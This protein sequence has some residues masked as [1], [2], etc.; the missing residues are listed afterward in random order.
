MNK[1]LNIFL[2]LVLALCTLT[3]ASES[4]LSSTAKINLHQGSNLTNLLPAGSHHGCAAADDQEHIDLDALLKLAEEN[5]K[6]L[7]QDQPVLDKKT[8][9]LQANNAHY[10]SLQRQVLPEGKVKFADCLETTY[11]YEDEPEN[12]LNPLLLQAINENRADDVEKLLDDGADID[13]KTKYSVSALALSAKSANLEIFKLLLTKNPTIQGENSYSETILHQAVKG[14]NPKIIS[15][16]LGTKQLPKKYL[17]HKSAFDETPLKLAIR[18]RNPAI[19]AQ[20]L[21]VGAQLQDSDLVDEEIM[22]AIQEQIIRAR[23]STEQKT[24]NK[25]FLDVVKSSDTC[26]VINYICNGANVNARDDL[27]E[28]ALM[29]ACASAN[30]DAVEQLVKLGADLD[31]QNYF[32]AATA[33]HQAIQAACLPVIKKLV[34]AGTSLTIKDQNN[35]TPVMLA[36][37]INKNSPSHINLEI[38]NY[39]SQVEARRKLSRKLFSTSIGLSIGVGAAMA[40]YSIWQKL[41]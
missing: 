27:G 37:Q 36:K 5:K 40:A 35:S 21:K 19:F 18:N 14:N 15:A 16:L 4:L 13:C 29:L 39:L 10:Q 26:S 8:K 41:R 30:E 25:Q 31:A 24:L 23:S 12:E 28:T 17:A 6:L 1:L 3:F 9:I 20:L 22:P 7:S 2:P 33:T 11:E 32:G 38:E 34:S